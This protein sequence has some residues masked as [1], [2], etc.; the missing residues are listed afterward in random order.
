MTKIEEHDVRS[1]VRQFELA[2]DMNERPNLGD[3]HIRVVHLGIT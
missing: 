1:S 2:S 3:Q